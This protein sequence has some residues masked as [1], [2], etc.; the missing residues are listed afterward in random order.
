VQAF[1]NHFRG[2]GGDELDPQDLRILWNLVQQIES[3]G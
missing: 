1:H 2:L 3:G